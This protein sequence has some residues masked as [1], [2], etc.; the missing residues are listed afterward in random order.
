MSRPLAV[1]TGVGRKQ[2]IGAAI[3]HALADVGVDLF[4]TY[5]SPYDRELGLATADEPREIAQELRA[6]GVRV[7]LW[8]C[9]LSQP[10]APQ[11]CMDTVETEMGKPTILVNNACVSLRD[12]LDHYSGELLDRHY[13]VNLRATSLLCVEFARRFTGERGRLINITT[14]QALGPMP[15]E[16]AYAATKAAI[17]AFTRSFAVEVAHKGITVNAVNPGPT[18]TGWMTDDIKQALL[19]RFPMGRIGQP[20]DVARFIRF[21]VSSDAD[22][23]TGQVLH[24]EGGFI[25]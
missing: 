22:W 4:L 9:D 20:E 23:I 12:G 25:R 18:D 7:T 2:G 17:E 6:K 21:L 19:P 14:G 10:D 24:S 13:A 8:E 1:V 11:K 16:W 3:S 15:G 5:W